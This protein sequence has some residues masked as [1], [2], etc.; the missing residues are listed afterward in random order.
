MKMNRFCILHDNNCP[1]TV[2][3]FD[4]DRWQSNQNSSLFC[5]DTAKLYGKEFVC[6]SVFITN[7][8]HLHITLQHDRSKV[9]CPFCGKHSNRIQKNGR[10][11][12]YDLFNFVSEGADFWSP[13][14]CL[15]I[16][17]DYDNKTYKCLNSKCGKLYRVNPAFLLHPK[18]QYTK[19]LIVYLGDYIDNTPESNCYNWRPPIHMSPST[20]RKL[21][22][23]SATIAPQVRLKFSE[24]FSKTTLM[25]KL[26]DRPYVILN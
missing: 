2:F 19:R 14:S 22:T 18:M 25:A 1:R 6:E 15:L 11:M 20:L 7:S 13:D 21:R 26:K 4:Y 5:I 16:D 12:V 10:R 23:Q 9:V 24:T 17:L 8:G 3:F